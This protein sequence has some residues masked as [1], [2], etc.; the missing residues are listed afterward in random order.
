MMKRSI[1]TLAFG[2]GCALVLHARLAAADLDI[3]PVQPG[4]QAAAGSSVLVEAVIENDSDDV[5]F[6]NSISAD[7]TD[8]FAGADLFDEFNASAPDS[9]LPGESWEGPIVRLTLAPD[10]PVETTHQI[11]VQLT[12]G[13][14]RYD[15]ENLAEFTFALNDSTAPVGV[16]AD[17]APIH[18]GTL[19]ASPNPAR[20]ISFITFDLLAPQWVDVLVYDIRGAAI[21]SLAHGLRNAGPQS[22]VWDGRNDLGRAVTPGVYFVTVHSAVEARRTKVVRIR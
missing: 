6:L 20:G 4:F 15:E 21:R 10:A 19:R 2:L 16:P 9:L 22:V 7:L 18:R 17:P 11:T 1:R 13:A 12:G 14:H 3:R 5:V 8:E